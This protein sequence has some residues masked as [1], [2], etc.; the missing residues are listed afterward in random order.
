MNLKGLWIGLILAFNVSA[1]HN[2]EEQIEEHSTT[3]TEI[4]VEDFGGATMTL[5]DTVAFCDADNAVI[6]YYPAVM[7]E[8]CLIMAINYGKGVK[9]APACMLLVTSERIATEVRTLKLT[10]YQNKVALF[11]FNMNLEYE[12]DGTLI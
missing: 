8:D 2:I 10:F 5:N 9:K 4:C 3:L 1:A 12:H 6:F 11:I 7:W